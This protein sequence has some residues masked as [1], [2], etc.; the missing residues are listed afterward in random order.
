MWCNRVHVRRNRRSWVTRALTVALTLS[1]STALVAVASGQSLTELWAAEPSGPAYAPLRAWP[2][3]EPDGPV[4]ES[5]GSLRE[6]DG[7]AYTPFLS[8]AA[9][10]GLVSQAAAPEEEEEGP[11]VSAFKALGGG[12]VAPARPQTSPAPGYGAAPVQG[13]RGEQGPPGPPGVKGDQGDPGPA[14]PP[15]P[16]GPPGPMGDQGDP[17]GAGPLGPQGP[18]GEKGDKGDPGPAGPPGPPGPAAPK[19]DKGDRGRLDAVYEASL[20]ELSLDTS[21]QERSWLSGLTVPV[22]VA[23][24]SKVV[25]IVSGVVDYRANQSYLL[26]LAVA[27]SR[28]PARWNEYRGVYGSSG[29]SMPFSISQT[30]TLSAGQHSL[31]F[32]AYNGSGGP[33]VRGANMVVFVV[34]E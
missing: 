8:S 30:L 17:G 31:Y 28:D 34:E 22:T 32:L 33:V 14:G 15:G 12:G 10:V 21:G 6:A 9:I 4:H 2:V 1:C 11:V 29:Q 7:P 5:S 20:G 16:P 26:R 18:R 27:E 25:V 24:R 13:P 3:G 23:K 19:D